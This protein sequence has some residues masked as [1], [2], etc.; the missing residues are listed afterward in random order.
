MK[1]LNFQ[2]RVNFVSDVIDMCNITINDSNEKVYHSAMFDVAFRFNVIKYFIDPKIDETVAENLCDVVYGYDI[3]EN[4]FSTP[5]IAGLKAA[6]KSEI[7]RSHQEFLTYAI[8]NKPNSFDELVDY[9]KEW[10]DSM[11]ENFKNI[12]V[13]KLM[14]AVNKISK[15]DKQDV[16]L[17]I[18]RNE[19]VS[20]KNTAVKSFIE[21]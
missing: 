19:A 7:S 6:C 17:K 20:S 1:I 3:D 2:E 16:A 10:F 5:Q 21:G 4:I 9:I 15:L 8:M 18:A 13:D 11:S 14:D 12:D